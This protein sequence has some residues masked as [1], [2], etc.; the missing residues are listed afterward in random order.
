MSDNIRFH[1]RYHA[2]MHHTAATAGDPDSSTDP[3]ASSTVPFQGDFYTAAGLYAG[4]GTGV[5]TISAPN[6]KGNVLTLQD[7]DFTGATLGTFIRAPQNAIPVFGQN[8]NTGDQHWSKVVFYT[9]FDGFHEDQTLT[10]L[11]TYG[12][13]STFNGNVIITSADSK[14]GTTSLHVSGS[15]LSGSV[16]VQNVVRDMKLV[17]GPW[18]IEFWCK[19]T[20]A[21]PGTP[22]SINPAVSDGY[23]P[24]TLG[25]SALSAFSDPV[26]GF[27]GV[28][29]KQYESCSCTYD[30][31]CKPP[32]EDTTN[33]LSSV[34]YGW[35]SGG[36]DLVY[37][38]CMVKYADAL[39]YFTAPPRTGL[40]LNAW[41][42]V[43]MTD[44]GLAGRLFINGR[45]TGS[46]PSTLCN[47]KLSWS[48]TDL[49]TIGAEERYGINA[50]S[51]PG[52]L[53]AD[54]YWT[55]YID[56][57]RVTAG[58]ARYVTNYFPP[59]YPHPTA[60]Y[61]TPE[62][63]PTQCQE[64][65]LIGPTYGSEFQF[66]S[67]LAGDN[68]NLTC[69]TS[70]IRL[71][72]SIPGLAGT[73]T[74]VTSS[75]PTSANPT[76]I[77]SHGLS[78]IPEIVHVGMEVIPGIYPVVTTPF[79]SGEVVNI[80]AFQRGA[81]YGSHLSGMRWDELYSVT[82]GPQNI[83]V[84][85][86]LDSTGTGG[87]PMDHTHE[88]LSFQLK[89]GKR[90]YPNPTPPTTQEQELTA[91]FRLHVTAIKGGLNYTGA[92]DL[93][94]TLYIDPDDL[95]L[96]EATSSNGHQIKRFWRV[97]P[98]GIKESHIATYN[99]K[100][101][102]IA[103]YQ[104]TTRTLETIP[105]LVPGT[106]DYASINVDRTG[107]V[108]TVEDKTGDLT[109][110][111][112][113]AVAAA[114]S[115][116]QKTKPVDR[117]PD[118]YFNSPRQLE[119]GAVTPGTFRITPSGTWGV[120]TTAAAGY[121][122]IPRRS[123]INPLADDGVTGRVGLYDPYVVKLPSGDKTVKFRIWGAG[124]GSNVHNWSATPAVSSDAMHGG[125][126][127]YS[128][129][130]YVIDDNITEVMVWIGKGGLSEN[131]GVGNYA[132]TDTAS[133]RPMLLSGSIADK[134]PLAGIW[135]D[136]MHP[137][138]CGGDTFITVKGLSGNDVQILKAHGGGVVY[139][140]AS[141]YSTLSS[142]QT[143]SALN[144]TCGAGA[145]ESSTVATMTDNWVQN[146]T[147]G[148]LSGGAM[149][150][151]TDP[152]DLGFADAYSR[153]TSLSSLEHVYGIT[154]HSGMNTLCAGAV[155]TFFDTVTDTTGLLDLSATREVF[156]PYFTFSAPGENGRPVF[157]EISICLPNIPD[158]T[159]PGV[160]ECWTYYPE[161][162]AAAFGSNARSYGAGGYV[163]NKRLPLINSVHGAD[164]GCIIE[165]LS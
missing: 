104:V 64:A 111:I 136:Q 74:Q 60:P 42:H 58:V 132:G 72:A 47:H 164:G 8:M 71:N 90:H 154:P 54:E 117:L 113:T 141:E 122:A 34:A 145:L 103:D 82:V 9:R 151:Y 140:S 149:T 52:Y 116:P 35:V 121:D 25:L 138:G 14:F 56:D 67:L 135:F 80:D 156:K 38:H 31:C 26:S 131:H 95:S 17:G 112:T 114:S 148:I 144:V 3:I 48:D 119:L 110:R 162:P 57:F 28:I 129:A 41:N 142:S 163:E 125:S 73:M 127:G 61:E 153:H 46:F 88:Q 49:F 27:G 43:A 32:I 45:Y 105:G 36:G 89:D 66:R 96:F 93:S 158:L 39:P 108:V 1:S 55:G 62:S 11:S 6:L 159:P 53:E 50:W 13:S 68:V 109:D 106:Y 22:F 10:D 115:T 70:S 19:P 24:H 97:R 87:I 165:I 15:P 59:E 18:T 16:F 78:G 86:N 118:V 134:D 100:T 139:R 7:T 5:A 99:I 155:E 143:L 157:R 33:Y 29:I 75:V 20:T 137:P 147:G 146:L 107:R 133:A 51:K 81:T 102:H 79:V 130:T 44:D 76:T 84:T 123:I 37:D 2:Q 150:F 30:A 128:E 101:W 120:Q 69:T 124:A 92:N 40:V 77:I 98:L 91:S 152:F 65:S 23:G 21:T 126:G 83:T 94:N 4:Y 12:R 161:T 63:N 85:R 160:T